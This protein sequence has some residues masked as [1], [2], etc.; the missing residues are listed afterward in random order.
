MLSA[1]ARGHDDDVNVK[2]IEDLQGELRKANIEIKKLQEGIE[3][4]PKLTQALLNVEEDEADRWRKMHTM[5]A[6]ERDEVVTMWSCKR[7]I[8]S[9]H[10]ERLLHLVP[11]RRLRY[12]HRHHRFHLQHSAR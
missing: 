9:W 12:Q 3:S 7:L 4:N 6:K 8:G 11:L 5:V 2:V 10:P 1:R